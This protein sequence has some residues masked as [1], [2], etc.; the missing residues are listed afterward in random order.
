MRSIEQAFEPGFPVPN[1]RGQSPAHRGVPR[2]SPVKLTRR[3]RLV[4]ILTLLVVA[5]V[6]F[7]MGRVSSQA[8]GPV[9]PLPTVTV[10]PGE[11]LWQI[12]RRVAPHADPRAMVLQ[13]ES[14][15]HLPSASVLAG[16]RLLLPRSG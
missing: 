5:V 3:G 9:R 10:A 11:T 13:L 7:S 6:G 15:N 1:F 2:R 8:A 16:Q 12:A 14:L 4:V